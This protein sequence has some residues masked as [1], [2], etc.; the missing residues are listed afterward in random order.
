MDKK[1]GKKGGARG[2]SIARARAGAIVFAILIASLSFL[3]AS[4]FVP[5]VGGEALEA[6]C[7]AEAEER[8]QQLRTG[9][10]RIHVSYSNN[11]SDYQGKNVDFNLTQHAFNFGA[12]FFHYDLSDPTND[13]YA[14]L[15]KDVFNFAVLPFYYTSWETPDYYPEESR[16]NDTIRFCEEHNITM[17]GHCLMWNHLAG[18]PNWL[19]PIANHTREEIVADFEDHI[20]SLV[21]KYK[22]NISYWDVTN[23]VVHRGVF[24]DLDPV[25][26]TRQCFSWA[27]AANP[28]ATLIFNEY[29]IAGHEFGNGDVARFCSALNEHGVTYDAIGDQVHLMDSDWIPMYEIQ[30]SLDGFT[31]LG[32]RMHI[33]EIMVP[34]TPV[35]ITN[36]WKKGLWSEENQAEYLRR[37]YTVCFAHPSIDVINYWGF[38]EPSHHTGYGLVNHNLSPKQ[39]YVVLKELIKNTWTTRGTALTN[40]S[41]WINFTGFFGNYNVTIGGKIF[42]VNTSPGAAN[43]FLLE[44]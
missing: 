33:T 3:I 20:T 7:V 30:A 18:I 16:V 9:P 1:T 11:G 13:V 10:F 22:G 42:Q 32:K 38:E 2:S 4:P 36:S 41:G 44:V 24:K 21:G 19:D 5:N 26:F 39:S 28:Q 40:T 34:S 8:I 14:G 17:K 23:E 43:E 35:P 25:E 12:M 15:W 31:R 29:A 37:L 6:T 27:R